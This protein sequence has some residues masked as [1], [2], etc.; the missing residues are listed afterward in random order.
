MMLWS[1]DEP[2]TVWEEDQKRGPLSANLVCPFVLCWCGYLRSRGF[3]LVEQVSGH[4]LLYYTRLYRIR[5][6]WGS[7][8][9]QLK[10]TRYRFQYTT[11]NA[12]LESSIGIACLEIESVGVKGIRVIYGD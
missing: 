2:E 4:H 1:E 5:G 6:S 9:T 7:F 3:F 12:V 10:S 11:H 8:L